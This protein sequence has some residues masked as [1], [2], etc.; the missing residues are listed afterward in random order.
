MAGCSREWPY[1]NSHDGAARIRIGRNL[2]C[3]CP[4]QT[5][6]VS[7]IMSGN[8]PSRRRACND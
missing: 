3:N 8:P 2:T 1:G 6:V 7:Q 4:K 5:C